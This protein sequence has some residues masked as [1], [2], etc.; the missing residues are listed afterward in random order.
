MASFGFQWHLSDR[1]NQ[2]CKHCYQE[3]FDDASELPSGHLFELAQR[4][5]HGLAPRRV[6]INLTGGEPLMHPQLFELI[7][8][9]AAFEHLEGV[10]LITNGTVLTNGL[11]EAIR[12]RETIG[13]I[14]ISLESGRAE[15]NDRIRGRG[16]LARVTANLSG[17]AQT[18][19]A[20][21]LMTTLGPCGSDGIADTV[22]FAR[23]HGFCG[24]IFE[25]FVPLGRGKPLSPLVPDP[26]E[27]STMKVM[28]ASAAGVE[29]REQDLLPYQALWIDL[30]PGAPEPLR[31]ALC[32]LGAG[33]MA[34][35]PDARVLPCRRLPEAVGNALTDP[36]EKILEGLAG[37][38]PDSL[39]PRLKGHGCS[40]CEIE[41]CAGCRALARAI[42]GDALA[43][44]PS[45][46]EAA[47]GTNS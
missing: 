26:A 12:T 1:C 9:L 40:S 29:A 47:Q 42:T 34:L 30:A 35:M 10:H 21:V 15:D 17:F 27:W 37:W 16:N 23:E 39:R 19:K 13:Q 44:D 32:N 2:R 43:D 3:R 20:L 41:G 25:R 14:K 36:F 38:A 6:S 4:V 46:S 22:A 33:S 45:C 8:R 28:I 7:D 5:M 18:G 11:I 31:G 24:V